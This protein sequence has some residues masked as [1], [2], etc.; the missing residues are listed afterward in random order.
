MSKSSPSKVQ[1][2]RR[3]QGATFAANDKW[4]VVGILPFLAAAIVGLWLLSKGGS[5]GV[6]QKPDEDIPPFLAATIAVE[7][8]PATLAPAQ[9]T[10]PSIK[11]A[12]T[13]ALKIPRVLAQQPCYCWCS[14]MG[15]RSLLDCYRSKHAAD[16]TICV[17]E[18][19]LANRMHN[20]GKTPEQIRTAIVAGEWNLLRLS[21]AVRRKSR[22]ESN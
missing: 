10:D 1:K 13:V 5:T 19:L 8:L 7:P 2:Q 9:F 14:R 3:K 11:E 4:R 16:C 18:A 15:H 20:T 6:T 22:G 17:K 21:M 12:Y